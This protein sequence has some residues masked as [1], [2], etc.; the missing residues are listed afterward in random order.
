M[1]RARLAEGEERAIFFAN[2]KSV[3]GIVGRRDQIN[4]KG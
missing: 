3:E 2:L 1:I 4:Q